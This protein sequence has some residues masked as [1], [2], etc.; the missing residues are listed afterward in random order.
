MCFNRIAFPPEKHHDVLTAKLALKV[1]N[2]NRRKLEK[3]LTCAQHVQ[4]PQTSSEVV[5]CQKV[6]VP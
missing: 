6:R 4:A 5:I 3:A 1:R 2:W